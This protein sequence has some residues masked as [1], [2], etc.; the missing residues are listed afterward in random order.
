MTLNRCD[1]FFADKLILI[2]GTVERLLLPRMIKEV[3][4]TLTHQYVSVIEVGGAYAHLFRDIIE[5]LNVQTLVITDIDAIEPSTRKA[6]AVEAGAVTSNSTLKKWIPEMATIDEL[7]AATTAD[8]QRERVV[9]AYQVSEAGL[10]AVGRSFEEAFILRNAGYLAF[11]TDYSSKRLFV[12]S[13]GTGLDEEEI[14]NT[15]FKIADQIDKKTDFAFDFLTRDGWST[16]L[17]IKL[18]LEWLASEL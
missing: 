9:V 10:P 13:A 8:K 18:G 16:P 7:L 14:R 4:S 1:M 6:V 2:E 12:D 3:A 17:Y 11:E 5:F 15:S